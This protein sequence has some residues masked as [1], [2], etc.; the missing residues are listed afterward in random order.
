MRRS[1]TINSRYW[2]NLGLALLVGLGAFVGLA[3]QVV[4]GQDAIAITQVD[5]SK[6][7]NMAIYIDAEASKLPA[8]LKPDDVS[9]IG[10]HGQTVLHRPAHHLT[11]QIGDGAMLARM[12]G[13]DVVNDF[14]S[15]DVAAGGQ[16]A[17]LVP[18]YHRALVEGLET[19]LPVAVLNIGGVANV[20]WVGPEGALLAFDTGPGNAAIDDWA[21]KHTGRPIDEDG[22]LASRGAVDG[23][24][25]MRMLENPWFAKAP[26]KSLD[27]MDFTAAAVDG[28]EPEDGA[29]T[30]TAFTALTV[31]RAADHFPLPAK[32]W[33]V[34]G[35]GRRNPVLMGAL[36]DVL[37]TDVDPVE[38]VGWRGDFL[39]AEAFAFLAARH[40]RGL[41]LSVPTTT[42]VPAPQTGG[43]LARK[44]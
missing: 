3:T 23:V 13:I 15:A 2:W 11:W 33:L 41:P 22:R 40:L 4:Y 42:G 17:P 28:M 10:F 27:R 26:P 37:W 36:A 43:R 18:L 8:G 9:L 5:P 38:A 21:L 25:T 6:F 14:R 30:L 35:G 39:E 44:P 34:C 12:T 29:A 19:Q 24:R 32:R 1:N 16:G 31:G 20:T 7:P